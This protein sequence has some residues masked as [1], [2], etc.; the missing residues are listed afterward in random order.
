MEVTNPTCDM[1]LPESQMSGRDGEEED[2]LP[3]WR[4]ATL[5]TMLKTECGPGAGELG[6]ATGDGD[7]GQGGGG[8][9]ECLSCGERGYDCGS[10]VWGIGTPEG[11]DI[12]GYHN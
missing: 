3:H 8:S 4:A 7:M 5:D 10:D 2:P 11:D 12:R 1:M 6:G 9:V